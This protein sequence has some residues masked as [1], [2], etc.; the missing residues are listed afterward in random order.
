MSEKKRTR[1]ASLQ[2]LLREALEDLSRYEH[3][4][5]VDAARIQ[6]AR[7]RVITYKQ[8][9]AEKKADRIKK[10]RGDLKTAQDEVVALKAKAG[11][12][13][14]EVTEKTARLE[15]ENSDLRQR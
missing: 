15:S 2:T 14:P 8:L 13:P 12:I 4:E 10:L 11:E 6:A 9:A 7:T 3:G 5:N 1:G